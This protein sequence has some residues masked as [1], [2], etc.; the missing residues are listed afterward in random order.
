[1]NRNYKHI[2]V[3]L[4]RLMQ[5]I[6]PQPPDEGHTRW[7]TEVFNKWIYHNNLGKT[8]LDVGCGDTA[9]MRPLFEKKGFSYTGVAI[10]ATDPSIQNMDFSFL[11]F[12]DESF[13]LVFARHSL[14]HSP[15]PLLTLMEWYRVAKSFLCIILPNPEHYG[16]SGMNHYSV[17]NR[18][19]ATFLLGR[20]GW[21][22]IWEDE[23]E[24]TEIRLMCEKVRDRIYG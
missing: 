11:E 5:D 3:Y 18:D 2:N 4:N 1:M 21:N 24:P 22:V 12:D 17:M 8:V 9:F 23:T 10:N 14:E 15:M 20:A 7:A 6:Y 19:Q 13:D 16:W